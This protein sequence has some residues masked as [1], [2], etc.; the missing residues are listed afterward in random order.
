MAAACSRASGWTIA[1]R[2]SSA[3]PPTRGS[4]GT[5]RPRKSA[6]RTFP[7]AARSSS[8]PTSWPCGTRRRRLPRRPGASGSRSSGDRSVA[9]W[10]TSTRRPCP[11]VER[12]CSGFGTAPS[13][14][15]GRRD[16][17]PPGGSGPA[18]A[19]RPVAPERCAPTP[20][21]TVAWWC[22]QSAAMTRSIIGGRPSPSIAGIRGNL[23]AGRSRACRWPR[24]P[25]AAWLCSRSGW[26]TA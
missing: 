5:A 16:D 7:D 3:I 23:W 22:S 10:R 13:T 8:P 2:R 11:A 24:P 26:M 17:S 6:W 12:R 21:T 14:T 9:R 20:S 18:S 19:G 4:R 25:R 15:A 1:S